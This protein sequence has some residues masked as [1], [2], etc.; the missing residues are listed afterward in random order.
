[1]KTH[2]EHAPLSASKDET[3]HRIEHEAE[4]GA[5][6]ALGGAVVGC[7]AGLPGALVGAIVGAIAGAMAGA[8]IDSDGV[9]RAA[10]TRRLDA[11]IGITGG[12]LGAPRLQHPP[13]REHR[14]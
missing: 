13:G 14:S 8:A 3:L 1:M 4:A 5:V 12:D 9:D 2:K 6:G 11:E 10:R 7:A